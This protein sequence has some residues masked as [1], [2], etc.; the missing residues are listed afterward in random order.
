MSYGQ[1]CFVEVGTWR[2]ASGTDHES[3]SSDSLR[4]PTFSSLLRI[5]TALGSARA[6]WVPHGKGIS[7]RTLRQRYASVPRSPLVGFRQP[8][9]SARTEGW[10][11][12]CTTWVT[13]AESAQALLRHLPGI[14]P[15]GNRSLVEGCP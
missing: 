5:H 11:P 9:R 2:S 4:S 10:P 14:L 3:P 6:G 8:G 1:K 15:A 13:G 7:L 12:G